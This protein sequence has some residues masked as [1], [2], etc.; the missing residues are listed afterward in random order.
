MSCASAACRLRRQGRLGAQP[1]GGEWEF[2]RIMSI[3]Q[4]LDELRAQQIHLW[5]EDGKLRYTA[6]AGRLTPELRQELLERKAELLSALAPAAAAELPQAI[7]S[8]PGAA[9][10]PALQ[11]APSSQRV[12]RPLPRLLCATAPVALPA[13]RPDRQRL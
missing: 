6:P 9:P 12:N 11:S 7:E 3:A 10:D 8:P 1:Q 13:V 4:F 2:G 5:V